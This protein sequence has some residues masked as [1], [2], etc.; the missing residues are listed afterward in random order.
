[1]PFFRRIHLKEN[2]MKRKLVAAGLMLAL[3][4]SIYAMDRK[5]AD[6]A[7]AEAGA[8]IESAERGDAAQ[9][10]PS[11]LDAAHAMYTSAQAAYDHRDWMESAFSA[12]DA[13]ADANLAAARSRQHR[14]EA[15]TNELDTTVRSLRE[16]VG[17]SGG[18]P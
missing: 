5:D 16:Q 14:A 12:D 6:L 11:D 4:M 13:K 15:T 8:S 7:L 10:A 9:Y 3:P 18:Q 1:L 2:A 17:I